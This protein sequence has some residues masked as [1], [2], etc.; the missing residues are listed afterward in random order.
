MHHIVQTQD[1]PWKPFE[2]D[3]LRGYALKPQV[4]GHEYTDAYSADVVRIAPGGASLSHVDTGRHAF[5]V[6]EGRG[7]FTLAGERWPLRPGCIV[8]V[9]PQVPHE[10]RNDGDE[11]L[12]LLALYDPPRQRS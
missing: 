5:Y 8:K 1:L 6:L 3:T 4:I 11:P 10:M 2:A 12:V 9:P 7:E